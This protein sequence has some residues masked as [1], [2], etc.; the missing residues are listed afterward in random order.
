M[1]YRKFGKLDWEVSALGFGAM[2]LP[3]VNKNQGN[4]DEP[5]VIRM[6]RYAFDHGVNYVDSAYGYHQGNSEV[7]I[8]KALKDGYRQKVKI[9][10]KIPSHEVHTTQDFDR[11]LN[12]ELKRLQTDWI[13]FYLLHHLDKASWPKV[14]DLGV[15]RWADSAI[16]DGRIG[17]FGFSFHD[18]F[19][20][21]QQIIEAYD[22][23]TLCQ[24]QY[25]YMDELTQAGTRGLEYAHKK[26]L[27]V[28]VM[29]PIRGGRLTRPPETVAKLWANAPVQRT[30]QEWALRWVWNHP[31]VTLALSGM[32]NMQ[33]VV[34]NVAYAGH[35][36]PHNLTKSDLALIGQVRDAYRSLSPVL[37]TACRYCMPCPN[38]VD[39]PHIFDLYNEAMI[40][41]SPE[42]PRKY[43]G[44]TRE[45]KREQ[46]ADNCIKC[47]QCLE[48]CPQKI[49]IPELLEEA[50]AF[51]TQKS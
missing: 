6:M 29:E 13:D 16:A 43:Y 1:Q 22:N 50:H 40:Y 23:W 2:R 42:K 35:S 7:V 32:S 17:Y 49:P 14:R 28:V 34:E 24:I 4:I 44:D 18:S 9:A 20:I 31:E 8:G 33:Q 3:V 46:R 48:K 36:Q 26:G 19:D 30:P 38:G 10:T 39:I 41:N 21:F 47:G 27:A 45:I 37:C 5:E 51:L 15:L 12:E 11:C 25:N